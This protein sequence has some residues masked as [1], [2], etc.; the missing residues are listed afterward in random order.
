MTVGDFNRRFHSS[1]LRVLLVGKSLDEVLALRA[2]AARVVGNDIELL[3]LQAESASSDAELAWGTKRLEVRRLAA[4]GDSFGPGVAQPL[5]PDGDVWKAVA[6]AAHDHGVDLVAIAS[7]HQGWFRRVFK[8]SAACDVLE[9]C[10][11]PV[12]AVPD[13]A[14][15]DRGSSADA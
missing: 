6:D 7:H 13:A 3:A 2:A 14:L 8:G 10:D 15:A 4:G 9:R 5:G 1:R 12:L 11:L